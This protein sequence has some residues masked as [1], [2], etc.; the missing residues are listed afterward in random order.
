MFC[1]QWGKEGRYFCNDCSPQRVEI[2]RVLGGRSVIETE[3]KGKYRNWKRLKSISVLQ[4]MG[5]KL[6]KKLLMIKRS[7]RKLGENEEATGR[8]DG[9]AF[10]GGAVVKT[11]YFN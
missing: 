1:E 3:N 6:E 2:G 11:P 7:W 9:R 5:G 4:K 10:P 8:N